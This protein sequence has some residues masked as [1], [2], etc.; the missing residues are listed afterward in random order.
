MTAEDVSFDSL[1]QIQHIIFIN[2]VA[3]NVFNQITA[4]YGV[5]A[6][7]L[8]GSFCYVHRDGMSDFLENYNS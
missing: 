1:C 6:R 7:S 2:L 5:W 4:V 8:H 3:M